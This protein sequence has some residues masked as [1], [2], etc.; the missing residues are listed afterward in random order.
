MTL[1]K[2][3]GEG[4]KPQSYR[5]GDLKFCRLVGKDFC[6]FDAH[7]ELYLSRSLVKVHAVS[8]A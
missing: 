2:E 5:E 1:A 3:R 7:S 4:M 6:L 8:L